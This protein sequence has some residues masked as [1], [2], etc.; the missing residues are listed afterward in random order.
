MKPPKNVADLASRLTEA[1]SK[2]VPLPASP[3]TAAPA[4]TPEP[5]AGNHSPPSAASPTARPARQEKP[6]KAAQKAKLETVGITLRPT[7]SL[8]Q[9]YTSAAADRTKR[10]GRVVSAQE[11]MI[12]HLERGP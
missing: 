6:P 12:E 5:S 7:R 8:L 3:P 11:V 1:A 9:R 4:A 2:P 10:E